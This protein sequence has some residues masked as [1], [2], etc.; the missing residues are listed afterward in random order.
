MFI[1]ALCNLPGSCDF[2]SG[3]CFYINSQR[4][5]IDWSLGTSQISRD[6]GLDFDHTTG[7]AFGLYSYQFIT[8]HVKNGYGNYFFVKWCMRAFFYFIFY[9]N[10]N[11]GYR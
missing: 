1:E 10:K 9:L 11:E 2:E 8:N 3:M 7:T 6:D 5:N 4:D